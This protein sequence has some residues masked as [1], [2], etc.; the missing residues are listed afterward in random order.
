M[1]RAIF[2]MLVTI[3]IVTVVLSGFGYWKMF[4]LNLW[5]GVVSISL[6]T[7]LAVITA[8]MIWKCWAILKEK[9]SKLTIKDIVKIILNILK[10][11]K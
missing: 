8:L 7:A 5:F 1:L 3:A 2:W 10:K 4:E 9:L 11:K 6:I